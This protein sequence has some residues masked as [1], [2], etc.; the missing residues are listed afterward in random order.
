LRHNVDL[1]FTFI[2]LAPDIVPQGKI[3]ARYTM[4]GGLKKSIQKGKGELILNATDIA[5]TMIL[6]KEITGSGFH[7]TSADYMETQVF[8]I[9]YNYKF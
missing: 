4:D 2:Y 5:N 6:R 3:M 8:R 9:G 1:Q 7:Y